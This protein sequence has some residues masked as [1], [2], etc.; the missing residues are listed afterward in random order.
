MYRTLKRR[1]VQP[2]LDA[3]DLIPGQ[4]WEVEIPKALL[5]SDA[6]VICLTPNSVDKEGY[7]QK[8]IKFAL[9]KAMEMPD[10]RIFII[11][12]RLEDCEL[13]FSL[14]KYHAVN[15]HE[16]DGYTKLMQALKLR[17]S[18]LERATV[19]LPKAGETTAEIRKV[20]EEKKSSK[21]KE[22]KAEIKTPKP[23]QDKVGVG[24]DVKE[25][26]IVS[27]SGNVVPFGR[28]EK[29]KFEELQ[30]ETISISIDITSSGDV[31]STLENRSKQ[32]NHKPDEVYVDWEKILGEKI[33]NISIGHP[34]LIAK[35]Y[36]SPFI[37]QLYF[38]E[39][40]DNVK[41][42]IKEIVGE[43]YT[44]RVYD[45]ELKFGQVVKIKLFSPDITFPDPI[46]KKLDSSINSMVFLGKP[47][48]SCQPREHK[49]VLSILDNETGIEH[50]SETFSVKVVD[51]AFDHVS[52]PLL[53]K[54]S[55]VALGIGSFSIFVLTLLEQI[56]KTIGFTSGTAAG[57]LAVVIY[58]NLYNFYQRIRPNTP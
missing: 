2:W 40:A 42:K 4:N 33:F 14:S 26:V 46:A 13:P 9:D 23:S 35:G 47:L 58:T 37:V 43:N 30:P 18:Q 34:K 19:E 36:E 53:S 20:V 31:A 39:L 1:G 48:D 56:D 45:T 10:G 17:A 32:T 54:V 41:M 52:R 28:K 38:K 57:V 8:E 5:S 49:V 29:P 15:L 22:K 55:T 50:Q 16:K 3:E 11:L 27:D 44:E 51:F 24:G 7:V 6:I 25:S 21:P 12:A